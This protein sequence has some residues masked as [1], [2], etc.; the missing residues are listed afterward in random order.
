[1]TPSTDALALIRNSIDRTLQVAEQPL[2]DRSISHPEE[3]LQALRS[4]QFMA[5]SLTASE[6]DQGRLVKL[7]AT[8][9]RLSGS[10][11]G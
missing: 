11:G 2:E 6:Q 3:L 4:L 9:E 5:K 10:A 1:L 7:A 8:I